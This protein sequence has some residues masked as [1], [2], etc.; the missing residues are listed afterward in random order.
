MSA[1]RQ[2]KNYAKYMESLGWTVD[3]GAFIK[4]LWFTSIVKI[5]HPDKIDLTP[6]KKYHPFLI[7]VEPNLSDLSHL[8]SLRNL[9]FKRDNWPL[10]PSKTLVLNLNKINLSKDV[11]YEI[12]KAE[13][14]GLKVEESKDPQLFYKILQETM[15][16]G[17]WSVPIKKEV[18]N[19]WK[20]FQPNNSVLLIARNVINNVTNNVPAAGC[21][22]VWNGDTAHYMYA[23]NT[24]EGRKCGAAYLTLWE[25]IKFC[26]KKKLKYLDLEGI[27]DERYPSSTKNWQ[28]FTAFKKQ[29]GGKVV[30]YPGSYSKYRLPT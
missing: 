27:Y 8:S 15:K 21:L 17:K 6:L 25:A 2:S 16:I 13:K 9:G 3:H 10:I 14:A 12:R 5:Q 28:G 1:L 7:K 29:W 18:I 19:L 11:R 22:L 20:S 24:A 26:Q 4:K 30:E 23:A